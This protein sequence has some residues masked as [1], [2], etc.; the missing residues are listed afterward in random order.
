MKKGYLYTIVFTML[1]AA[2]FTA[3]LAFAQGSLTPKII[4]NQTLATRKAIIYAFDMKTGETN[5]AINQAFEKYIKP[6]PKNGVDAF[7]QVDDSGNPLGY[8][9]P[10][11]GSALW[12]QVKGYIALDTELKQVKGLTFTEQNETPGLGG[13]IDEPPFKEQ[14]RGLTLPEGGL[15]YGK[16]GDKQIDAI[17]GAT[18]T[19]NS[20][21]KILNDVTTNVIAKWGGN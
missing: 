4:E 12:G 18:L 9:F 11:G 5:E 17:T 14:F 8:A 13:R 1:C 20:V 2:I 7:V 21:I 10:F 19:S 3:V 15:K 6:D 16:V